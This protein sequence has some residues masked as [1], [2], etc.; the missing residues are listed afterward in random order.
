MDADKSRDLVDKFE[1]TNKVKK[2]PAKKGLEKFLG[3]EDG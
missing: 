1:K 3:D 2:E